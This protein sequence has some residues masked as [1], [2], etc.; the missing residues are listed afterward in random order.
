MARWPDLTRNSG[1]KFSDRLTFVAG[2]D[3]EFRVERPHLRKN[4]ALDEGQVRIGLKNVTLAV[5]NSL[6]SLRPIGETAS[7]R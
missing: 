5:A 6:Q 1:T 2:V 7:V 3:L 4:L